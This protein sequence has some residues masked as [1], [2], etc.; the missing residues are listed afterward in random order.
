MTHLENRL[1]KLE[2][3]N[4]GDDGQAFA[5]GTSYLIVRNADDELGIERT[6]RHDYCFHQPELKE[7]EYIENETPLMMTNRQLEGLLK[8]VDGKTRSI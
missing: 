5:F 4:G 8:A 1:S 7:G 6:E 3:R 2:A